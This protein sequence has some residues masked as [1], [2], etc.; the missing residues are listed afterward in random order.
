MSTLPPSRFIF[1]HPLEADPEGEGLVAIGAD[2]EAST[3]L[4]AYQ[5]GIFPWFSKDDP[6]CW[7][8]PEPRCVIYPDDFQ[9]SKSLVRQ[10]KKNQY[11]LTL[12]HVFEQVIRACAQPRHYAQDTWISEE[13]VEGYVSLHQAGLAHSVEVW[14]DDELVGGLYGVQIGAAFFGES[15]FSRKTDVSKMAFCFLM[16]LCKVSKFPWVDCQLPNEHLMSLGATTLPRA[17]FLAQLP[18]VIGQNPPNWSAIRD[19]RFQTS[20]ILTTQTLLGLIKS[21]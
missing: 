1:P 8:S 13:I 20:D 6:I 15:M 4:E 10:L 5:H 3:I 14:L 21:A 16:Q 2:L 9:P 19:Y 12:N 11:T 17:E 7:W 18:Q